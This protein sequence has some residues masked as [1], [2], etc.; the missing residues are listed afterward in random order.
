MRGSGDE[1]YHRFLSSPPARFW[2]PV[3]ASAENGFDACLGF[4]HHLISLGLLYSK[5][6]FSRFEIA[7]FGNLFASF[8]FDL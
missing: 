2:G 6:L 1:V 5:S 8:D 4:R 7:A 3:M